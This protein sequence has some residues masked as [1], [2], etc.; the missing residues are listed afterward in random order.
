MTATEQDIPMTDDMEA[1]QCRDDILQSMFW[2][3]GEGIADEAD[4][5][6]LV[7]FLGVD[8]ARVREQLAILVAN[9]YVQENGPWYRLSEQGGREGG[10]RFADEMADLQKYAHGECGPDCPVCKGV[11]RDNC[12]HC[13]PAARR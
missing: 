8:V 13:A 5:P 2:M 6:M 9:G 4:V 3:R 11:S 10:R 1:L 7:S 12:A